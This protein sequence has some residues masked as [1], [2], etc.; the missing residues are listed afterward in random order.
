VRLSAAEPVPEF[1]FC[2][3]PASRHCSNGVWSI[4]SI[5]ACIWRH[6]RCRRAR[7]STQSHTHTRTHTHRHDSRAEGVS[8]SFCTGGD[9]V[10]SGALACLTIRFCCRVFAPKIEPVRSTTVQGPMLLTS[11]GT[12]RKAAPADCGGIAGALLRRLRGHCCAM[13]HLTGCRQPTRRSLFYCVPCSSC[14]AGAGAAAAPAGG[15][16][17]ASTGGFGAFGATPAATTAASTA[18]A[19]GSLLLLPPPPLLCSFASPQ[20]PRCFGGSFWR[21]YHDPR[22]PGL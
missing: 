20:K 17:G 10:Q 7:A 13:T 2:E 18:P 8:G 5:N 12:P 15:F 22:F 14:G 19:A 16:G 3:S 21:V 6:C 4:C 11:V 9:V 1:P